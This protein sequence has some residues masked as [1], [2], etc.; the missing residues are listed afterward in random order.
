MIT[1]LWHAERTLATLLKEIG[2]EV[3]VRALYD[4]VMESMMERRLGASDGATAVHMKAASSTAVRA[5]LRTFKS[6]LSFT[7]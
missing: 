2:E 1:R 5:D 7:F 6:P 4:E 3:Q